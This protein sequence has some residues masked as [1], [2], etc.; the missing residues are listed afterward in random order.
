MARTAYDA[1][2]GD[3]VYP[4]GKPLKAGI[5]QELKPITSRAGMKL[6]PVVIRGASVLW[7]DGT[8]TDVAITNL[9]KLDGLIEETQRKLNTHLETKKKL[10]AFSAKNSER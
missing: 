10:L 8:V 5:I 1:K 2:P 9:Q 3:F 4:F 6:K 7:L